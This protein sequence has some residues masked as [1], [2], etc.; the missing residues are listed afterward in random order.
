MPHLDY[1]LQRL[2]PDSTDPVLARDLRQ[3]DALCGQL[4]EAAEKQGREVIVVSEYG[5]TATTD[6]VHINRELRKAGFIKVREEQGREQLDAGASPAFALA[7]HQLAHIYLQHG[8]NI[9]EVRALVQQLDGVEQVLDQEGIPVSYTHLTL[10]T[11]P[12]V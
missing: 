2:G 11:T 5:I 12:Y 1:N 7:D 6:A 4:I 9:D 10:P 3:I 8:A